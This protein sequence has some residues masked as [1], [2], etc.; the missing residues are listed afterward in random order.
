MPSKGVVIKDFFA[1]M[2]AFYFTRG[3]PNKMR[4]V[5]KIKGAAKKGGAR[6]PRTP[7]LYTPLFVDLSETGLWTY[8]KP[9]QGP[10]RNW[11]VDLLETG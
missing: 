10:I 1:Q 2:C 6:T 7:P 3:L 9:V 5:Q 11:F 8:Q 4:W